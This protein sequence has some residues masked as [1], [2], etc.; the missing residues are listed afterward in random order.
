MVL[1][2]TGNRTW[3]LAWLLPAVVTGAL[4]D[5]PVASMADTS[6]ENLELGYLFFSPGTRSALE[7]LRQQASGNSFDI[8]ALPD[9]EQQVVADIA[10]QGLVTRQQ[11][12]PQA[13]WV[14]HKPQT[15]A[16]PSVPGEPRALLDAVQRPTVPILLPDRGSVIELKVGQR[17]DAMT[18]EIS[19]ISLSPDVAADT[20]ATPTD[21]DAEASS[22][23]ARTE[24]AP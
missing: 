2:M 9:A 4:A 18:G 14:N 20:T 19:N 24:A 6:A 12:Q 11:G 13:V 8:T 23:A 16:E 7:K 1:I 21:A 15:G 3:G 22:E 5:T 10:L 17:M